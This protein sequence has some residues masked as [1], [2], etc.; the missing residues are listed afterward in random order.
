M[1]SMA[2]EISNGDD[3]SEHGFVNV[4]KQFQSPY[5]DA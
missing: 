1:I 3:P 4:L 2:P 5:R